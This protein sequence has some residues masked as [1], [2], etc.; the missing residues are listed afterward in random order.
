MEQ[1]ERIQTLSV[2]EL[3]QKFPGLVPNRLYYWESQGWVK[4]VPAKK[5][6]RDVK[7]YPVEE[8]ERVHKAL[9]LINRGFAPKKAF[10]IVNA[11]ATSESRS[12]EIEK[13]LRLMERLHVQINKS[14]VSEEEKQEMQKVLD[15]ITEQIVL[16]ATNEAI[17]GI[18]DRVRSLTSETD[19]SGR[20]D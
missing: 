13:L 19:T 16:L 3:L 11:G 12:V 18:R 9:E 15:E 8:A 4:S 14:G 7:R 17:E 20:S 6:T 2:T 10:E 5:G 1:R